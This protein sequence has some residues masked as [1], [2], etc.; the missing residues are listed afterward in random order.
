MAALQKTYSGDL[1]TSIARQLWVARNIAAAAKA[2]AVDVAKGYGVD[3]MLRPGEF[4]SRALQMQATSRLPKRFQRQMPSVTMGD[5]SFL[6]RGQ[7]TPFSSGI[8]PKPTNAQTMNRLAGQP[9]PWLAVGAPLSAQRKPASPSVLSQA[10][11]TSGAPTT[12][13]TKTRE[14]GVVVKDQQLGNFLAAV[15]LSLSSSLNSINKKMDEANEGVIVAK[16][17][18]DLT[19]KKLEANSD[20]LE[21]KLDAII[22][23]LR[24]ANLTEDQKADRRET[25]SKQ[26]EQ[27]MEN[28]MSSANRILMQ[29]MDQEEIR[30]M[31]AEDQMDDDRGPITNTSTPTQNAQQLNLDLGG[32]IPEFERGGIA[33]GPDS[34]YL[35][36]LHGDEAVIP[37]DNNYTQGERTALDNPVTS[38]TPMLERGNNF[39]SMQPKMLP[40]KGLARPSI[41]SANVNIGSSSVGG[42]DLAAA[43]QLPSK[44]AGIVTMGLMGE[45]LKN[46]KLPPGVT[47]HIKSISSPVAAAFGIPDVMSE[48][49]TAD[50]E[51][52]QNQKRQDVLSATRGREGRERGVMGQIIDFIAGKIPGTGGGNTIY[53]RTSGGTGGGYGTGGFFGGKKGGKNFI[54]KMKFDPENPDRENPHPPGTPLYNIWNNRKQQYEMMKEAGMISSVGGNE[55]FTKNLSYENAYDYRKFESP[56][57]GLKTSEVAYNMSMEDEMNTIVEGLADPDS[58]MILNNQTARSDSDN[59]I[60]HSSIANRGNPLKDGIYLGAYSV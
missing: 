12:T 50:S 57:Y 8:N 34:G 58:Q 59:Q 53:N 17:G 48:D 36:V 49:L 35:A 54:D 47:A 31:R 5:P 4:M 22:D 29:D 44:A 1:S 30:A 16:D 33:S 24:F 3:P 46:A 42:T 26:R 60:E 37:L 2:D 15:A 32:N 7:A 52:V 20:S 9:F 28:D 14:K 38:E 11:K 40:W 56:E 18:I 10:S 27:D 25:Q 39:D 23:A 45:V 21:S 6:A 19:Y 13:N 51:F 41:S 43:I 55:F